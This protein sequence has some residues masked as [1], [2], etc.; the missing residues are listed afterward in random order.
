MFNKKETL[1]KEQQDNVVKRIARGYEFESI[2]F[3]KFTKDS[4]TGFYLLS[5]KINGSE[6]LKTTLSIDNLD[7]LYVS[8]GVIGLNPINTFKDYEKNKDI[9]DTENID[10]SEIKVKY[11]GE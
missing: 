6:N 3:I 5:L 11:L 9:S 10:L 1:T 7:D 4:K 2:E 8:V